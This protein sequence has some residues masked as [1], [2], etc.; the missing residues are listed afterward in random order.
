ME[1]RSNT[2]ILKR[3]YDSDT[4]CLDMYFGSETKFSKITNIIS[5][6]IV[7]QIPA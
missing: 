1:N 2:R 6:K 3:F 5:E 4:M 7:L